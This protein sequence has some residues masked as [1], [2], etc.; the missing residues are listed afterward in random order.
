[1]PVLPSKKPE[2]KPKAC[3][4]CKWHREEIHV[5]KTVNLFGTERSDS[6]LMHMCQY[7]TFTYDPVTGDKI[8]DIAVNRTCHGE[9]QNSRWWDIN[10]QPHDTCGY[11]ATHFTSK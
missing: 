8:W 1:M 4:D 5:T 6:K 7:Q 10:D 2:V 9:R 3:V 11:D